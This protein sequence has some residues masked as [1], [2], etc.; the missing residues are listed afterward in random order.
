MSDFAGAPTPQQGGAEQD[1]VFLSHPR[2]SYVEDTALL[3]VKRFP[4]RRH[5]TNK[6]FRIHGGDVHCRQIVREAIHTRTEGSVGGLEKEKT[7]L[8][9]AQP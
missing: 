9:I 3:G 8:E 1:R 6:L 2:A 7:A 4:G 5:N